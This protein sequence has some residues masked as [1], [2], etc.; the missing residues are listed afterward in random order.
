MSF[1]RHTRI[2]ILCWLG[3]ANATLR[4][5]WKTLCLLIDEHC[6]QQETIYWNNWQV[7]CP[8]AIPKYGMKGPHACSLFSVGQ[9]WWLC[10]SVWSHY[11]YFHFCTNCLRYALWLVSMLSTTIVYVHLATHFPE[12][13]HSMDVLHKSKKLKQ[14][15]TKVNAIFGKSILLL[16]INKGCRY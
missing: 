15:L 10:Y 12:V 7:R 1:Y 3:M 5:Q 4:K 8:S 16:H 14:A 2:V 6:H 13:H 11:W 9:T